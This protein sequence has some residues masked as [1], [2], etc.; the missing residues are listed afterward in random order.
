M[1]AG[2]SGRACDLD[3]ILEFCGSVFAPFRPFPC[4]VSEF[5]CVHRDCDG[6]LSCL[7]ACLPVGLSHLMLLD[8]DDIPVV[9]KR[10][11]LVYDEWVVYEC[12]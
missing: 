7:L 2:V 4:G 6:G 9:E 5:A 12:S 3:G 1:G 8:D 10:C 11:K